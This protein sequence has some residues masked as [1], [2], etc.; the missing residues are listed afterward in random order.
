MGEYIEEPL[1]DEILDKHKAI[2]SEL[3]QKKL[4]TIK[5]SFLKQ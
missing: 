5:T 1:T 3:G 4:K 2:Y